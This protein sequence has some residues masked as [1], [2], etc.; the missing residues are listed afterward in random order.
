MLRDEELRRERG[1]ELA[2]KLAVLI[3]GC[4]AEKL[5]GQEVE[6]E[7]LTSVAGKA[8]NGKRGCKLTGVR[9]I[10]KSVLRWCVAVPDGAGEKALNDANLNN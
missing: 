7:G 8:L 2:E 5:A 10:N 9:A 1:R 6:I 4:F 3:Q